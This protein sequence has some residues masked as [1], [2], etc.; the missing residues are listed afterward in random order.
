MHA[1]LAARVLSDSDTTSESEQ[2]VYQVVESTLVF[3]NGGERAERYLAALAGEGW[4]LDIGALETR[5][6]R[7]IALSG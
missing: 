4:V 2:F 7:R 3:L 1:L 5:G 6:G